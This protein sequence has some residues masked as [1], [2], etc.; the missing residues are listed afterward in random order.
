MVNKY[1]LKNKNG[2]NMCQKVGC[3]KHKNLINIFNGLFCNE[4]TREL[5]EIRN[6]L[7]YSK[8][9]GDRYLEDTT[10]QQE[11]GFRKLMEPGH[12]YYKLKVENELSRRFSTKRYEDDNKRTKIKHKKKSRRIK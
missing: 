4:H 7:L 12:M 1:S 6:K 3:R 8:V 5:S 10:R 11:I 2:D 9:V